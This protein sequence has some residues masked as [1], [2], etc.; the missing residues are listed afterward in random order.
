MN[1]NKA[2]RTGYANSGWRKLMNSTGLVFLVAVF[3]PG[4]AAADD[5]PLDVTISVVDS[6]GDLPDAVTKTITLPDAALASDVAQ[7]RSAKGLETA[8]QARELGR[9]FGQ[10]V[11]EDA[12][13]RRGRP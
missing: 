4:I 7:E 8:N 2:N 1:M 3:P 9:E 10:S 11:A 12:K 5:R 6:P 13:T